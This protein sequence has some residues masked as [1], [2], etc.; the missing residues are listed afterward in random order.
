[1]MHRSDKHAGGRVMIWGSSDA[2]SMAPWS[3]HPKIWIF[4]VCSIV[5][6]ILIHL[7]DSFEQ[8]ISE[9]FLIDAN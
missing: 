1:M 7:E 2:Q 3:L 5:N 8:F 9:L 4:M 6:Q